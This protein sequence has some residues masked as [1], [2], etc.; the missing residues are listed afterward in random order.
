MSTAIGWLGVSSQGREA[1]SSKANAEH[2]DEVGGLAE[3]GS[4]RRND[5][6]KAVHERFHRATSLD[7]HPP[8]TL[9]GLHEGD[10]LLAGGAVAAVG[11]LAHQ[12]AVHLAGL[13]GA[14][15]PVLPEHLLA[16]EVLDRGWVEDE[17][18][19]ECV[20]GP[21]DIAG[22]GVE[23]GELAQG[24]DGNAADVVLVVDQPVVPAVGESR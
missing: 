5:L 1:A 22:G 24:V 18:L 3:L 21:V 19:V 14:A 8:S 13:L 7:Y 11:E 17:S 23:L 6:L 9:E 12:L 16:E 20:D 4:K 10:G 15:D 2:V